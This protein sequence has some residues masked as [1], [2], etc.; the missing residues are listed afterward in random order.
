MKIDRSKLRKAQSELVR[1]KREVYLRIFNGP[2]AMSGFVFAE[3]MTSFR[4]TSFVF[5]FLAA[6]FEF[7]CTHELIVLFF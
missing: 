5:W 4:L 2:C 7:R 6:L 3:G 1:I